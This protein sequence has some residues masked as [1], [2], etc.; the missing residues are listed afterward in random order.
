MN[1]VDII[2]ANQNEM[3]DLDSRY[4][5]FL[6]EKHNEFYP[7][8]VSFLKSWIDGYVN[9]EEEYDPLDPNSVY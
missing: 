8:A 2:V 7:T 4:M 1:N 5:S 9:P 3:H 6:A